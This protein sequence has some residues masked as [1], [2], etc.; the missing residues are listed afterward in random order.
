VDERGGL[1]RL[2]GTLAP[3]IRRGK[4]PKFL[5]DERQQRIHRLPFVCHQA[6]RLIVT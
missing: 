3:Q 4:A 6:I 2:T 1:E 5:V